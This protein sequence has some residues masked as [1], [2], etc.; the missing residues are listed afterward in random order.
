MLHLMVTEFKCA[1]KVA[2]STCYVLVLPSNVKQPVPDK[3]TLFITSLISS[4]LGTCVN[5]TCALAVNRLLLS[6]ST[7]EVR[8]SSCKSLG[9]APSQLRTAEAVVAA[10]Y[11]HLEEHVYT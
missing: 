6:F 9:S 10:R 2:D 3:L 1:E 4:R 8:A 5:V 7:S 11:T